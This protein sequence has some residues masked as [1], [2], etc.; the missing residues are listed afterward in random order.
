MPSNGPQCHV[1][2]TIFGF[3]VVAAIRGMI[4]DNERFDHRQWSIYDAEQFEAAARLIR[5]GYDETKE[6]P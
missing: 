5:Q 6:K 3:Q 2:A 1:T 4:L